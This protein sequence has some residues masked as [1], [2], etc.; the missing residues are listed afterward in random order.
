VLCRVRPVLEV[1]RR[2]G[3]DVDVTDIPNDEELFIQRDAQTRTKYEYDRVFGQQSSQEEVFEAVQPLCVSVLDG[4]NV[5][6]FAYG[7][8]GSGMSDPTACFARWADH[9]DR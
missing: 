2:S 1:E 3:E 5:C 6:I 4:Y 9:R 8:T 7:Q